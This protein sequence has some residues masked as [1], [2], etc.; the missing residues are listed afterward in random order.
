MFAMAAIAAA[1]AVTAVAQTTPD[2]PAKHAQASPAPMSDGEVRKINK[3]AGK[4]T[5]K[6]GPIPSL[7]MPE[8]TMVFR[9]RD[10]AMLDQVEAGDKVRFAA[11]KVGGLYTIVSIEKK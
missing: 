1:H 11:E 5:L 8:M 4:I 2:P 6:H 3:G 7:D 10:P 9:V